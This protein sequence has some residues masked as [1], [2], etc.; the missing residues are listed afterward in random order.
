MRF[1][2][3]N[4]L[5]LLAILFT[6]FAGLF[7][8]VMNVDAAQYASMAREMEATGSFLKVYNRGIDYLDKPPLL[9]WFSAVAFKIL[10]V[11]TWVYK[12]PSFLFALLSAYALFHLALRNYGKETAWFS[13]FL[14]MSSQGFF[15]MT[16]DVRTDLLLTSC[17]VL[18]IA[19]FDKW[20][21]TSALK[22]QIL[23]GLWLGLALLAKGPLGL[24]LPLFTGG[25]YVLYTG[26]FSKMLDW[27]AWIW[28][29]VS[30]LLLIPMCIGLWQQFGQEGLYFFFWKQSFGRITGENEWKNE[31]DLFFLSQNLLWA[32]LPWTLMFL[33]AF[34]H[35]IKDMFTA[36]KRLLVPILPLSGILFPLLTLSTSKYQL[37]HYIFVAIPMVCLL[38]GIWVQRQ[39]QSGNPVLK[40]LKSWM[41]FQSMLVILIAVFLEFFVLSSHRLSFRI[42]WILLI[43]LCLLYAGSDKS[44][45]LRLIGFP[46][47]SSVL[48]NLYLACSFYPA[49]LRYQSAQP[50]SE[51]LDLHPEAK[52]DFYVYQYGASHALDFYTGKLNAI[53]YNPPDVEDNKAKYLFTHMQGMQELKKAGTSFRIHRVWPDYPV[54]FLSIPFLNPLTRAE[55]V[56][57]VLLLEINK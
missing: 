15:L 23:T 35:S 3:F 12:L 37:P 55:Q 1:S 38:T 20:L 47:A 21:H 27:K 52:A 49:L 8:P 34:F 24:V 5:L 2:H 32:V 48:V 41:M 25:V 16:Q 43:V 11:S 42:I 29:P 54:Q 19:Q 30:A 28:L 40:Y 22:D 26:R 56:Q 31:A 13:S 45:P 33:F 57:K 14:W 9:F 6:A 39:I 50:V 10:G 36:S 53:L 17:T 7:I 46:L 18:A 4:I 51:W 44:M